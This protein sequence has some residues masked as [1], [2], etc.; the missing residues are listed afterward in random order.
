MG[1]PVEMLRWFFVKW[2]SFSLSP[3]SHRGISTA[4]QD[5]NG[6]PLLVAPRLNKWTCH[7]NPLP[8]RAR[9]TTTAG[10]VE[11]DGRGAAEAE[12]AEQESPFQ[13]RFRS[14]KYLIRVPL[15]AGV[16]PVDQVPLVFPSPLQLFIQ[17]L[18]HFTDSL[19]RHF[20]PGRSFY[21]RQEAS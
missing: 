11:E 2:L 10:K 12:A 15:P 4:P 16:I 14:V 18:L 3:R 19:S 20:V 21:D 1:A 6:P 8:L 13:R 17:L 7:P 5:Y 9:P